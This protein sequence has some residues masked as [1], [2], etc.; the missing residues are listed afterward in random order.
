MLPV[1]LPDGK[2]TVLSQVAK[3]EF[4]PGMAQMTRR[5]RRQVLEVAGRGPIRPRPI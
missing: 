5:S 1:T 4:E 3:A 2:K